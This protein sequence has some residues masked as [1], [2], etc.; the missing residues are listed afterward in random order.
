MELGSTASYKRES[1][2]RLLPTIE[3]YSDALSDYQKH[4]QRAASALLVKRV[5]LPQ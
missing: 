2:T 5:F 1:G 4:R 3:T